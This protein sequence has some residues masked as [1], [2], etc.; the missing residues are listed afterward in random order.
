MGEDDLE[1]FL[2]EGAEDDWRDLDG[3]ADEFRGVRG[4]LTLFNPVT[5]PTIPSSAAR[6]S[7][8]WPI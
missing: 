1:P 7:A 5:N 4:R 6:R 2:P 8:S 3:T